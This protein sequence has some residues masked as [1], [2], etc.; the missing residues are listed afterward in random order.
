M[1]K[2]RL[3]QFLGAKDSVAI[4]LGSERNVKELWDASHN[5]KYELR[6]SSKWKY[7]VNEWFGVIVNDEGVP[8]L[9]SIIGYSLQNGKGGKKFAFVG[10]AKTHPDFIRRGFMRMAREKALSQIEGVAKVA[11]FSTQRKKKNLELQRPETHDVV[12]DEVI[13][14][15]KERI[16][17]L[18]DV[19]DWG[20]Y[21]AWWN[22]IKMG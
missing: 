21:K 20:I 19:N 1:S 8:K 17:N 18:P 5:D 14:F 6:G 16:N 7:P 12:P 4:Q 3:A 22:I 10:G 9:V 13:E 15:M 11:G 2:E